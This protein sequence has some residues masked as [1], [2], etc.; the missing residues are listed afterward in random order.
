MSIY[1]SGTVPFFRLSPQNH[2]L[3]IV[4][5]EP[6]IQ[7]SYSTHE[8]ILGRVDHLDIYIY[9]YGKFRDFSNRSVSK[10]GRPIAI[11]GSMNGPGLKSSQCYRFGWLFSSS[12]SSCAAPCRGPRAGNV[13]GERKKILKSKSRTQVHDDPAL[14]R[15]EIVRLSQGGMSPPPKTEEP[16]ARPIESTYVKWA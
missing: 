16:N 3:F 10:R 12:S 11:E 8:R 15:R 1:L 14:R 7:F 6:I 13:V 4:G 9:I 2:D 5:V